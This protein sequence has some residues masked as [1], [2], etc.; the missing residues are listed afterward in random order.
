MMR[1][2]QKYIVVIQYG[3]GQEDNFLLPDQLSSTFKD[4]GVTDKCQITL[5][6]FK[7]ITDEQSDYGGE[8]GEDEQEDMEDEMEE[9]A[10]EEQSEN[11]NEIQNEPNENVMIQESQAAET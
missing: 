4:C 10:N 9:D 5:V 11:K 6:E 7:N 3:G 2:N 1:G 8:A